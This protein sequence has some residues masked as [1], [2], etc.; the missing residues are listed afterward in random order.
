MF[1]TFKSIINISFQRDNISQQAF[2]SLHKINLYNF[3]LKKFKL[4]L[5]LKYVVINI[6]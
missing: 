6:S 3:F 1:Q 5:I 4:K 2:W